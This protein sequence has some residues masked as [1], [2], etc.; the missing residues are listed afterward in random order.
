MWGRVMRVVHAFRPHVIHTHLHAFNYV[1][2][3]SS[4]GER[5]RLCIPYIPSP[6]ESSAGW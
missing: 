1:L 6:K 3:V 4:A 2:P 5:L